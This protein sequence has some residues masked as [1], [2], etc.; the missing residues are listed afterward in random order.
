MSNQH[1]ASREEFEQ[2]V[3]AFQAAKKQGVLAGEKNVDLSFLFEFRFDNQALTMK[4][5]LFVAEY[6][7]DLAPTRAMEAAGY[8]SA[9]RKR[10]N[11][12][13]NRPRIAAAIY[14][15]IQHR[16]DR[17]RVSQDRVVEELGNLAFASLTDVIDWDDREVTIKSL[18][19]IPKHVRPAIKEISETR[20]PN[21]RTLKVAMHDKNPALN[22]LMRHFGAYHDKMTVEHKLDVA[23]ALRRAHE[24]AQAR[25]AYRKEKVIEGE[26]L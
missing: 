8:A 21:G 7:V 3:E 2:Y 6:L 16:M 17:L 25:A 22:N 26:T 11:E 13:M 5:R 20:G 14:A 12:L 15:C 23:D 4:E 19:D 18:D 10:A 9:N 24:R 1:I